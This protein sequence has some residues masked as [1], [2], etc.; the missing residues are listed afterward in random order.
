MENKS[1]NINYHQKASNPSYSTWV[2]AS[3]GTGKTHIL[4]NRLLRLMLKKVDASNILCLTFTRAAAGEMKTRIIQTLLSWTSMSKSDLS[5][6]LHKI[7]GKRPNLSELNYARS[8]LSK[9][10]DRQ[11]NLKIMTIHAFCQSLLSRFPIEAGV[12]INFKIA[13]TSETAKLLSIARADII[14]NAMNNKNSTLYKDFSFLAGNLNQEKFSSIVDSVILQRN[15]FKRSLKE[16]ENIEQLTN[17]IANKLN[18]SK[19]FNL[20]FFFKNFIKETDLKNLKL[21]SES[22]MLSSTKDRLMGEIILKCLQSLKKLENHSQFYNNYKFLFLT[23]TNF[24]P[25][26]NL[27]SKNWSNKNPI[28]YKFL[29][30]EQDRVFLMEDLRKKISTY[31]F[32]STLCRLGLSIIKKYEEQKFH[33]SVLDYEDLISL[34]HNLLNK[35]GIS[36]WILFKLDGG[37]DHILVDEAQDTSPPQWEIIKLLTSD[38][39]SGSGAKENIN[40]TIFAV[41][42][43]KQSIYGF[44][45]SD[46][47]EFY[48][49]RDF[50]SKKVKQSNCRWQE[51]SLKHSYRTLPNILTTVDN[52]IEDPARKGIWFNDIKPQKHIPVKFSNKGKVELW[53]FH[54]KD[55]KINTPNIIVPNQLAEK[56]SESLKNLIKNQKALNPEDILILVSKREPLMPLII[57][58]LEKRNIPVIGLDKVKLNK[59]QVVIDLISIAKFVLL[60]SDNYNLACLLK[61]PLFSI[62]EDTLFEITYKR[63]SCVWEKIK[64]SQKDRLIKISKLLNQLLAVSNNSTPYSFFSSILEG[65]L[66]ARKKFIASLGAG[67][68]TTIAQFL[69]EALNLEKLNPPSLE[70][71]VDYIENNQIEIQQD[72]LTNPKA[73][74]VMT[75]HGSKG[76]EAKTTI[77]ADA[78]HTFPRK[79]YDL[80]WTE[81]ES[82]KIIPLWAPSKSETDSITLS[83]INKRHDSQIREHDRL[84]YVAMTRAKNCLISISS[85][86]EN[87]TP[88]YTWHHS[89]LSSINLTKQK[90]F[91]FQDKDKTIFSI[92]HFTPELNNKIKPKINIPLEINRPIIDNNHDIIETKISVT[93]LISK[94]PEISKINRSHI[95][96]KSI[97][98]RDRGKIIHKILEFARNL[99][100]KELKIIISSMIRKQKLENLNQNDIFN[101]IINVIN[102][103]QIKSIMKEPSNNEPIICSKINGK[104]IVGRVDRLIVKPNL[105]T[106]LDFKTTNKIPNSAEKIDK[107]L[108]AQMAAYK[109]LVKSIWKN[110]P[111]RLGLIYTS[112]PK[113]FWLKDKCLNIVEELILKALKN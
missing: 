22:L 109:I 72:T 108:L 14:N 111:V 87:I 6:Q 76:L 7:N 21:A 67:V 39:F 29:L 95:N 64:N 23:K 51:I 59:Q 55:R 8:L 35:P 36:L 75:I 93:E 113:I 2:S 98:A 50:Y 49:A 57:N 27:C 25:K 18:I 45:G 89:I 5:A 112:G 97:L 9:T 100:K 28:N 44:Q 90:K 73:I 37:I 32:T 13:N 99:N 105:I 4:I 74:R 101:E 19:S 52:I 20:E 54:I 65:K 82:K 102:L 58:S 96:T 43:T 63:R 69:Q 91:K 33:K 81:T 31:S 3:A 12:P 88:K 78:D 15:L 79:T 68:N 10:L 62:G 26:I 11:N 46:P 40:R 17:N 80:V 56:I 71:F 94:I 53:S 34:T 38:F 77:I 48:R 86:S 24:T 16:S 42:D 47:N 83:L 104:I 1:K 30:K 106:V 107:K 103:S 61:S 41:G 66:Q 70:L 110:Q 85:G 92:G 84:L 60:P